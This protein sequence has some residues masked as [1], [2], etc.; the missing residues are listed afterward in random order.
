MLFSSYELNFLSRFYRG[1]LQDNLQF[2]SR[3]IVERAQTGTR[4]LVPVLD[5]GTCYALVTARGLAA[6]VVT[7][8]DYPQRTALVLLSEVLAVF[9]R[10]TPSSSWE[11]VSTDTS[12]TCPQVEALFRKFQDPTEADR[13]LKIETELDD[14]KSV[15][16]TSMDALMQRGET[17]SSLI[18]KTDDLSATSKRFRRMAEENNTCWQWLKRLLV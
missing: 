2:Q 4:T 12:M 13:I 14:V 18:S 5:V 8:A 15:V 3:V 16:L 6:A 9:E 17:L 1:A 11:A 10:E 7:A